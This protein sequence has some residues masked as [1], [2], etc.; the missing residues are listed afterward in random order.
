MSMVRGIIRDPHTVVCYDTAA[1]PDQT[2]ALGRYTFSTKCMCIIA[3][4]RPVSQPA[5]T[6]TNSRDK[7]LIGSAAQVASGER[8]SAMLTGSWLCY[9]NR[10]TESYANR[11]TESL[12]HAPPKLRLPWISATSGR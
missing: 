9:A 1:G 6:S 3:S 10:I 11:I 2:D 5:S 7:D 4:M 12:A 8:G